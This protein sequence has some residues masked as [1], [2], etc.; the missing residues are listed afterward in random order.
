MFNKS[1][2]NSLRDDGAILPAAGRRKYFR[3]TLCL[4]IGLVLG[5]CA[6][7]SVFMSY[8]KQMTSVK[9]QIQN[10]QYTVVQTQ[11]DKHREDADHILYMMER[12]RAS[13]IATDY[14][15]SIEDFRQVIR[16]MTVNEEKATITASGA[17]AAGSAMFTNDNAIPYGGQPYERIFVHQFQALNFLFQKNL[18][19]ALVE[20]RRANEQQQLSLREHEDEVA[21]AEDSARNKGFM[22]NFNSME[23]VAGRVKNSF[24]NAYT[25]YTSGIIYE[26]S[27]EDNDA[28]IDYK[29]ALEIFPDNP[30]L[31]KD[32]LRLAKK[33]GMRQDYE[34]YS[35]AFKQEAATTDKDTGD[36]IVLFEHGFAPVRLQTKVGVW[37]GDN[38]H[39]AAFPI[40]PGIWQETSPLMV[41]AGG[42][43][44]GQTSPIVYVQSLA[45]RALQEQLPGMMLRQVLRL[46]TKKQVADKTEGAL[47]L[48][49]HLFNAFTE[50][51]DLRSWLTLPN[52]AQILRTRLAP[53]KH[54][55]QLTNGTASGSLEVVVEPGRRTIVRVISTGPTMHTH[56]V[57]I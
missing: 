30:Y 40:Y 45:T 56:V 52:D 38:L 17:A 3:T 8:P 29:K 48:A 55:L 43:L 49:T 16:A 13:Q 47:K 28:Y 25:F 46:A 20:V 42:T 19:A 36:V 54:Q 21:K 11:L 57:V 2:T 34:R 10:K 22:S 23:A 27:G 24:Q 14:K 9:Q 6:V 18:D 32:V 41:E 35:K 31:Q 12:A 5:G 4:G 37:A 7:T 1:K 26:I 50:N 39:H 53:G 33:L 44:I 51:A 15:A